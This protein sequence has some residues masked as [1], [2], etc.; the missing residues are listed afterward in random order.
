MMTGHP[1]RK[2]ASGRKSDQ[3]TGLHPAAISIALGA[4]L[5]AVVG[6]WLTFGWSLEAGYLLAIVSLFTL[7]FFATLLVPLSY[8]TDDPRWRQ[9]R[10]TF[11]Q[12]LKKRVALPDSRISGRDALL[13]ILLLPVAL[14]VAFTAIGLIWT[15]LH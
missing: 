13:Q 2:P 7:V 14:T 4:T 15:L 3:T 11:N 9:R 10:A 6:I 12:F 8:A 5:V 1:K